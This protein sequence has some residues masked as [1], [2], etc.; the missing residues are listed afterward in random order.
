MRVGGK[1]RLAR[2]FFGGPTCLE[3]IMLQGEVGGRGTGRH[4]QLVVDVLHVMVDGAHR[5]VQALGHLAIGKPPRNESEDLHF[6]LAQA[7]G[8]I[9][10]PSANPVPGRAEH[11]VGRVSIQA[12]GAYGGLQLVRGGLWR[13]GRT[14]RPCL[15]QRVVN[16]AAAR[17]RASGRSIVAGAPR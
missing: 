15:G 3:Q 13:A 12:P 2:L 1:H 11:G 7:S 6:A 4:A 5:E 10:L 8:P 16:S 17:S 14:M 9:A